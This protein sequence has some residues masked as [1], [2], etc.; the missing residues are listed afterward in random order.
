MNIDAASMMQGGDRGCWVC[1]QGNGADIRGWLRDHCI[2]FTFAAQ[3]DFIPN[4]D[5][6]FPAPVASVPSSGIASP[7]A[8]SVVVAA[9]AAAAAAAAGGHAGSA[10]GAGAGPGFVPVVSGGAAV[11]SDDVAPLFG[12]PVDEYRAGDALLF[13]AGASGEWA[14]LAEVEAALLSRAAAPRPPPGFPPR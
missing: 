5:F 10:S 8:N 13:D 9:A 6:M 4:P 7:V 1:R 11:G 3:T 14:T 12:A 2:S